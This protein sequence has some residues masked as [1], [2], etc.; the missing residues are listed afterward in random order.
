[1]YL[2]HVESYRARCAVGLLEPGQPPMASDREPFEDEV[3][4][5]RAGAMN[6]AEA[7]ASLF[8]PDPFLA[9]SL[10]AREVDFGA[11]SRNRAV[12]TKTV[13]VT[14]N[15]RAKMTVFWGGQDQSR[16]ADDLDDARIA[17]AAAAAE[18]NPFSV[19]PEQADVRP[20]Q[21]QEFR[22]SFRPTKDHAYYFR[23]LECFAYVKSMRSF[24][25]VTEENFTPPWTCAVRALGHTFGHVG[26]TIG[27]MPKCHFTARGHRLLFPPTVKGDYSYQTLALVNDGDTAVGFE[28]PV[29]AR[30]RRRDRTRRIALLVL[31]HEGRRGPQVIHPRHVPLRREGRRGAP[32]DFDVRAQRLDGERRG[33]GRSRAGA[34]PEAQSWIR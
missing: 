13:T 9:V 5:C 25:Q 30:I 27:F 10:D 19:F 29:Q 18:K 21:S 20:G 26:A 24:R 11:C 33:V 31:P 17:R 8:E 2:S 3:A 34:R 16:V 14:N 12:E 32:R 7:F 6:N 23:Q 4:M 28:F 15:S 1:M 22:V